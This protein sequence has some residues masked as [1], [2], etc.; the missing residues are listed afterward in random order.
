MS[1]LRYQLLHR[2]VS[3]LIQAERFGAQ[4]AVLL[5]QSFGG[6]LDDKSREDYGR[7]AEAMGCAPAFNAVTPVGRPTC[8][9]LMIGWVAEA[10]R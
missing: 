7:F 1:G 8:L 10:P 2:A 3:A 5:V 4:T 9:P 6:H